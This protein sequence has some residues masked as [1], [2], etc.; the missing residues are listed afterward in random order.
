MSSLALPRAKSL[1]ARVMTGVLTILFLGGVLVTL[2]AWSN[3]RQAARQAYDRILIG[4]AN[5]IAESIRI[6]DGQPVTD[7]PVSAFEL[8]AQAP[9]D[10]ITYAVRGPDLTLLTGHETA[11]LREGRADAEQLYDGQ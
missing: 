6:I 1:L 2:T 3:G 8:L 10:R 4:A 7:L 9:D 5:D 11:P